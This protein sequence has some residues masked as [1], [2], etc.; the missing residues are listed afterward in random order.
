MIVYLYFAV[1]FFV[2]F[3]LFYVIGVK[4]KK[5]FPASVTSIF[6]LLSASMLYIFYFEQLFVKRFGGSMTISVP[7]GMQHISSTWKADNL[8]VENYDPETNRCIFSEY[9]RGHVLEGK[10]I[11]K[12]C[13][14][15]HAQP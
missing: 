6:F 15:V 4:A 8:W 11:I 14:P 3:L 5:W 10:V 9:S 7:E 1:V 2:A 13:S 12:N